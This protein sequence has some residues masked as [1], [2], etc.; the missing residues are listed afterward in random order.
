MRL[1]L[2]P[3]VDAGGAR[4]KISVQFPGRPV[5]VQ[6]WKAQVGRVPLY[7]LDTDVAENEAA[8]RRI[9]HT[10]YGGDKET[11]I[12]Q[13]LILGVGGVAMVSALGIPTTVCHM[14]EGHSAFI[15]FARIMRA[16]KEQGLPTAEATQLISAGTVFT[17][18]TPVPAG[19]DQFPADLMDKYFGSALPGL[20][21]TRDELLSLGAKLPGQSGQLFNMAILALRTADYTNAVSRLHADVSRRLWE[22]SWPG[23]PHDEIPIDYVTN[24]IH[25]CT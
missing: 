16:R 25:V 17:T 4:I 24:G 10:L 5:N 7:L 6:A 8:D 15:Q 22:E 12:Q 23:L 18:H 14:N 19:I 13:E 9:T 21:M 11:R 1:P 3:V 20:G 2:L